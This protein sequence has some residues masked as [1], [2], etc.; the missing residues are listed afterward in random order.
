MDS[1]ASE[2]ALLDA[3]L[4]AVFTHPGKPGSVYPISELF[5]V[6]HCAHKDLLCLYTGGVQNKISATDF[7]SH[8]Q[9]PLSN[10]GKMEASTFK[11]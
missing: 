3:I 4:Q 1:V 7:I 11:L 9:F 6:N 2:Q 10:L 5:W 8:S